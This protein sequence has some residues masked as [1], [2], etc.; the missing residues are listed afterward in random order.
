[1]LGELIFELETNKVGNEKAIE[2]F[3]N[4]FAKEKEL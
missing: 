4:Y 1:M 3:K 2:I